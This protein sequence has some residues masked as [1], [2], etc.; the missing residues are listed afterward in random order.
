MISFESLGKDE[1][2]SNNLMQQSDQESLFEHQPTGIQIQHIP[3][4]MFRPKLE[5]P[6][7]QLRVGF[8]FESTSKGFTTP[9]YLSKRYSG[10]A[11]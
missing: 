2:T 10:F 4:F 9:N 8:D 11:V 5:A 7:M 1:E 3:D 6:K